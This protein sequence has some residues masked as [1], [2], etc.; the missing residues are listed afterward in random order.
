MK[1]KI[2]YWSIILLLSLGVTVLVQFFFRQY[3]FSHLSN[4]NHVGKMEFVFTAIFLP[5]YLKGVY[6]VLNRKFKFIGHFTAYFLLTVV[7][8]ILSSRIDFI[9][10]WDTTGKI[11]NINDAEARDVIELGLILQFTIS[12]ILDSY[13]LFADRSLNNN[14]MKTIKTLAPNMNI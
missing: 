9:N 10:W 3:R 2:I 11:I 4:L 13:F 6:L 5:I 1:N 14:K 7:C 8:I 12:I